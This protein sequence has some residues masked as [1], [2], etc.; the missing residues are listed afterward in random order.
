V[1]SIHKILKSALVLAAAFIAGG[2]LALCIHAAGVAPETGGAVAILVAVYMAFNGKNKSDR[3]LKNRFYA[4]PFAIIV[5]I[6][7]LSS[8]FGFVEVINNQLD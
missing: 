5:F 6:F 2:L 1:P 3:L 8:Y 7:G 4:P